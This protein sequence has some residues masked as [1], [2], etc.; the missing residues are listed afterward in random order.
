MHHLPSLFPSTVH[1]LRSYHIPFHIFLSQRAPL[2]VN[3]PYRYSLKLVTD[4]RIKYLLGCESKCLNSIFVCIPFRLIQGLLCHWM[5]TT[6]LIHSLLTHG[7]RLQIISCFVFFNLPKLFLFFLLLFR[8]HLSLICLR[9]QFN[10]PIT[11]L[12]EKNISITGNL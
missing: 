10:F 2:P 5:K 8:I 7:M 6:W 4:K 11:E 9:S 1:G 12:L 3:C